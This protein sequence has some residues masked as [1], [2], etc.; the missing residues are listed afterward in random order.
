MKN[1]NVFKDMFV[2]LGSATF[3]FGIIYYILGVDLEFILN[4]R[5]IGKISVVIIF[6]YLLYYF[7][8]RAGTEK[9]E[10]LDYVKA[11]D[12]EH[13]E[14]LKKINPISE[15][16][17]LSLFCIKW[18]KEEL[19][20]TKLAIISNENIS[21]DEYE[22]HKKDLKSTFIN[23]LFVF[24]RPIGDQTLKRKQ[25]RAMIKADRVKP[26]ILTPG[27]LLSSGDGIKRDMMVHPNR[28]AIRYA[29]MDLTPTTITSIL[30][31]SVSIYVFGDGITLE[32]I[33]SLLFVIYTFSAASI[34][35]Y[36]TKFRLRSKRMVEYRKKQVARI[37]EYLSSEF[38]PQ[39]KQGSSIETCI[40]EFCQNEKSE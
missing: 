34:R 6:T 17:P 30:C 9:A 7:W 27:M 38:C 2:I 29:F 20:A 23:W 35:G 13:E 31:V 33:L 39:N 19:M 25:I 28:L 4:R 10:T 8:G 11:A 18:V 14:I 16:K 24:K 5:N 12:K 32:N 26:M 21:F 40:D 15:M 36:L 3:I 22:E 1:E 37:T